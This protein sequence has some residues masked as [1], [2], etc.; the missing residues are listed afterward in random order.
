MLNLLATRR[1]RLAAFFLLYVTE[2]IP[3][4]FTSFAI[5]T[6]M[7]KQGVGPAQ[8]GAFV[9]TLYLP[10]AWKWAAGPFV[11]LFYSERLGRR[12][13][14]VVGS[15]GMMALTL[16]AAMPIDFATRLQLFTVAILAHNAFAAVQD[17]AIDA[18]AVSTLPADE[19]GLANGLMFA[20]S[21]IGS[22]IGGAGVLFLT[23]WVPFQTTFLFVAAAIL[24]VTLLVAVPLHEPRGPAGAG[25]DRAQGGGRRLARAAGE[26]RA[27]AMTAARAMVGSRSAFAG[28]AFAL[29]PAGAFA[30]SMSLS[31]TLAVDL[32]MS[33][34]AIAWQSVAATVLA[35]AGCVV[36]GS[37]SDRIGRRRALALYA[38]LTAIPTVALGLY[39]LHRGWVM[40]RPPGD[41]APPAPRDLVVAFWAA[42]MAFSLAQGLIYGTRTAL[43]MDLCEPAVAATQ[44]TAYM[45][46]LN[47]V[48]AYTSWWQGRAVERFGYPGTLLIDAA[49]GLVSLAILPLTVRRKPQADAGTA[50]P[51]AVASPA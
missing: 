40:P 34:R 5:A 32:G 37:V 48:N 13:A 23:E 42:V 44:F 27:Y 46:L 15:Q 28:L 12:R 35:A 26:V 22:G 36:G 17:V 20:G 31:T 2:G 25:A 30:L 41:P 24:A 45:A 3:F 6:V 33:E 29:L 16:L 43:F 8:I 10:W 18:L 49:L 9:A 11:D 1:G 51:E 21:Y 4:G 50:T 39:F 38:V 14:W 47:L 7:R 19:R